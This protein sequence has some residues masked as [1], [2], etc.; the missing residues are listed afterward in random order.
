ML[1]FNAAPVKA[2]AGDEDVYKVLV[3]DRETK[4]ILA[5]LLHVNEL[6]RHGVTLHMLLDAERQPIPDVPAVYFVQVRGRAHAAPVPPPPCGCC[7]S[8]AIAPCR[9]PAS[10]R[11]SPDRRAPPPLA[12]R[13]QPSEAAVARIVEDVQRGLYDSFHLN[14][15]THLPRPLLEKLA[16]GAGPGEGRGGGMGWA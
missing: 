10:R 5:P 4:D 12:A 11:L 2:A 15:S 13:A 7:R 3:L 1:H 16:A 6:R 8:S 14:F 9:R